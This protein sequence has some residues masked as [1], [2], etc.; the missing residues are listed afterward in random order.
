[1][2]LL[3]IK[4]FLECR[5]VGLHSQPNTLRHSSDIIAGQPFYS[6]WAWRANRASW[7]SDFTVFK[8]GQEL[9]AWPLCVGW[10]LFSLGVHQRKGQE[11]VLMWRGVKVCRQSVKPGK[12]NIAIYWSARVQVAA[13][14][15]LQ[16]VFHQD[17]SETFRHTC[18]DNGPHILSSWEVRMKSPSNQG[19]NLRQ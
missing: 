6:Q 11:K 14:L 4:P 8:R 5:F 9:V 18:Q 19:G 16:P 13:G 12:I 3:L 2:S 15:P 10:H 17:L 1:M 7:I